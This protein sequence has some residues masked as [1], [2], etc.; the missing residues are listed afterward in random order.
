MHHSLQYAANCARMYN[1]FSGGYV[2]F[3]VLA[4]LPP[5]EVDVKFEDLISLL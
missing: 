5:R 1:T 2:V 3:N 4:H